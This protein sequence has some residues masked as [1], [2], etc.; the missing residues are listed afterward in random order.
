MSSTFA[1]HVDFLAREKEPF[2][3]IHPADA[4]ARGIAAGDL[5]RLENARSWVILRAQVTDDICPGVVAS[6]KGRWAKNELLQ[7]GQADRQPAHQ[8]CPRR[9]CRAEYLPQ[10]ARL[11]AEDDE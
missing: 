6:P 2:V 4:A 9:F 7:C 11:G 5:V 8:R 3:E 10:H 1:N